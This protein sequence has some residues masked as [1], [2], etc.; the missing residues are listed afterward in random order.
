MGEILNSNKSKILTK[1]PTNSIAV[2]YTH[3]DVYK[4]QVIVSGVYLSPV[5]SMLYI[6]V[7]I[8]SLINS[9]I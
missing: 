4:R 6:E 1:N 8:V 2:S 5:Q 7:A 9:L 3:L